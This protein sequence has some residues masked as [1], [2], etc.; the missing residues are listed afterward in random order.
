MNE[1]LH[2]QR[3][4]RLSLL[5]FFMSR[6]SLQGSTSPLWPRSTLGHVNVL[7][8]ATCMMCERLL[9]K[10]SDLKITQP[11]LHRKLHLLRVDGERTRLVFSKTRR[12]RI[13]KS[14]RINAQCHI[15]SLMIPRA[16]L[17]SFSR[18]ISFCAPPLGALPYASLSIPHFITAKSSKLG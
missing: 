7:C 15:H 11:H 5:L 14:C 17:T 13:L 9:P 6:V 8:E 18:V 12:W 2:F 4:R 10:F 3:I 16:S 1:I